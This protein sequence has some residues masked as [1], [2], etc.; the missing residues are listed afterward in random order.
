MFRSRPLFRLDRLTPC[1]AFD[2]PLTSYQ[3]YDP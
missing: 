2:G 1:P 3:T